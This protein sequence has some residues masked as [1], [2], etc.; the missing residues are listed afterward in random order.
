MISKAKH[1]VL[2]GLYRQGNCES[3]IAAILDLTLWEVNGVLKHYEK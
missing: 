3:V 2:I 1:A